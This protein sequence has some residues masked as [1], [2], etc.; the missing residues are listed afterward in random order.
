MEKP[1]SSFIFSLF[2]WLLFLTAIGILIKD[3]NEIISVSINLDASS[4]KS[5]FEEVSAGKKIKENEHSE[6]HGNKSKETEKEENLQNLE[7]NQN[8][9]NISKDAIYQPLPQIPNEL[10]S[11]ALRTYAIARFYLDENGSVIKVEL[12]KP[13]SNFELDV[14]LIKSLKKWKF[15]PNSEKT[16][17]IKVHFLVE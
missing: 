5:E 7:N 8:K 4:I 11:E 16:K 12:I 9:N 17:E 13:S 6:D 1:I 10:R 15:N 3:Q 14:L 2:F